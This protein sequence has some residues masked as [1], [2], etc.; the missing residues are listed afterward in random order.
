MPSILGLRDTESYQSS[1]FTNWRREILYR[2]PNSGSTLV[3]LLSLTD[4]QD[5]SSSPE[6]NW[7]EKDLP[8]QRTQIDNAAGYNSSAT[9]LAVDDSSHFR[10]GHV[11]QNIRTKELMQVLTVPS[12]TTITVKRQLQDLSGGSLTIDDNDALLVIGNVNAEGAS[13][14]PSLS[15]DP[16]NYSNYTQIFRTPYAVSG[17]AL[18]T[19]MNWDRRGPQPELAREALMRHSIEMEKAFIFGAKAKWTDSSSGQVMRLT[20][21]ITKFLPAAGSVS[22]QDGHTITGDSDD[23]CRYIVNSDGLVTPARL[24]GWMERVFRYTSPEVDEK[25]ALA[26]SGAIK[27]LE[28]LMKLANTPFTMQEEE[29]FGIRFRRYT[30]SFGSILIKVHPLFSKDPTYRF[31]ML[32]VDVPYLVY[33]YLEGR[34]TELLTN[35]QSPGA[36]QRIDEWLT[37]CGLEVHHAEAHMFIEKMNSA[38]LTE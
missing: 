5:V 28:S 34:D 30:T 14:P 9:T 16:N 13:T 29:Y 38:A 35:R 20:Q 32:I 31:S 11:V 6:F 36:D 18:K 24:D 15:T 21:G 17:T 8:S 19:A 2:F 1:V 27:T 33:R 25:L 7:A 10:V 37:E 22:L 26:G 3:S 4:T 23:D 12:G